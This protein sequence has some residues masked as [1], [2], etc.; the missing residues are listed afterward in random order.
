MQNAATQDVRDMR[1]AFNQ[2]AQFSGGRNDSVTVL[3]DLSD[4]IFNF[5][6]SGI[7]SG[8]CRTEHAGERA[9]NCVGSAI[10]V[11]MN[12]DSGVG[13]FGPV[14]PAFWIEEVRLRLKIA[15]LSEREIQRPAL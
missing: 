14:L 12:G 4:L 15:G 11:W 1:Q 10:G 8:A 13:T 6:V 3:F 5:I 2:V 9:I 7:E